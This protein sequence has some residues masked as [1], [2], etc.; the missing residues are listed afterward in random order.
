MASKMAM[1]V[2]V[3]VFILVKVFKN[4]LRNNQEYK[5]SLAN[6]RDALHCYRK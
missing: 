2:D 3:L 6:S 4:P 5:L 1:L